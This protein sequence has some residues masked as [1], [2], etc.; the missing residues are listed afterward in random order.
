MQI[1]DQH[2]PKA[3]MVMTKYKS[4]KTG[5]STKIPLHKVALNMSTS[6]DTTFESKLCEEDGGNTGLGRATEGP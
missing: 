3:N 1:S 5:D 4:Q 2:L 6:L